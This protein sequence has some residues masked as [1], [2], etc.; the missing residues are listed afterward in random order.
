[1]SNWTVAPEVHPTAIVSPEATLAEGVRVG[2]GCVIDGPVTLGTGVRLISGVQVLGPATIGP[3]T[4]VYPFAC[5]GFPAQDYKVKPG[6]PTLGI[7]IGA[8][9]I[10]R[11]HVTVH[12]ATRQDHPTTLGDGV[13]MMVGSHVGHDT[14]IGNRVIMVNNTAL[15]GHVEIGDR[16]NLSGHAVVHQFCRVGRMAMVSGNSTITSDVPP[17]CIVTERNLLQGV[18][19]VGLRR[20]GFDRTDIT[21]VRA[22]YR[23]A[24]RRFRSR[25]DVVDALRS[26][27]RGHP[28]ID[29]LI[30]FYN[31]SKRGVAPT[32]SL[33]P[34]QFRAWLR[35][36]Q[37]MPAEEFDEEAPDAS[38]V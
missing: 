22:A 37:Q 31:S 33:P 28:L 1:M 36:A 15:A 7:Q 2:P 5:L 30:A 10:I 4:I 12:A 11:E 26:I 20:A 27:G 21:L 32:V 3:E 14:R 23:D 9:C 35:K 8:G 19:V 24:I 16:A 17:F 6:D 34:R 25:N 13:F 29:E 38:E 18:N